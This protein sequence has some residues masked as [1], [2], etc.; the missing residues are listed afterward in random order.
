M[1]TAIALLAAPE[2]DLSLSCYGSGAR[3]GEQGEGGSPPARSRS[4]G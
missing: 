2:P 4:K 1:R 3:Q